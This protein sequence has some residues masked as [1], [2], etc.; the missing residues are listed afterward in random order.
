MKRLTYAVIVLLVALA[1]FANE[2]EG[3]IRVACVGNSV[4][5][6]FR[7]P[8]RERTAYPVVLQNLLGNHYE[9]RNF[10]HSGATLLKRGHK[11]YMS[12]SEFSAALD[13]AADIVV[14]HLGLNDTDPRN[15]PDFKEDFITDYRALIDSF[16]CANPKAKIW[17]CKMTPIFHWHPRF[18]SGTRD[19]HGQ[20]QKRI[21]QVARTADVSLIDFYESLHK[22]PDLFPDA[23]HP[24]ANGAAILARTVYGAITGDYGGLQLPEL[25][26]NGMVVQRNKEI[27]FH[28][29]ADA[30]ERVE[31]KFGKESHAVVAGG[32]GRWRVN[33][34]AR[35]AGGPYDLAFR[36]K[37]KKISFTD[38]WTGDVW[39]CSGQSNMEFRS[40][41]S[42]TAKQDE[43]D[44]D[45]HPHI[46][47]F[48]M[49][50]KFR[51]DAVEWGDSAL[52]LTNELQHLQMGPW[53][54]C[55]A[56][57]VKT[58]SAVAF[59]FGR[60]L[61]DSLHVPIG[62]ICNAVGGSTTESWIDRGTLERDYP[63]ILYDWL[64]ND[65]TQAWARSRAAQN[66][67]Q[68]ENKFQRHPYEPCYLYEA[69]ILP[70]E[71]YAI[72]GIIWYQGESNAHNVEL[73]ERLFGL[74]EKSW[75]ANWGEQL[76]F[77]F[78]QLSS[79]NRP[80]WPTF[81][82]SQRLLAERLP[83]TWMAVST[84]VGDSLDVHPRNK[85]VVGE[86]LAM[87]A[88][89]HTY[90]FCLTS[91]GPTLAD[92]RQRGSQLVLS[93]KHADGMSVTRGFEIAG[94]DGL[95]KDA[96]AIVEGTRIILSA[97]GVKKPVSVR[98]G[99]QPFTRADLRNKQGLPASTFM[100][101]DIH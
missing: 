35:E 52:K 73:H 25:Y 62:L 19:W 58:F 8:E 92:A 37:K 26:G 70:L 78:V 89:N 43:A 47:L 48:N 13:F 6:G 86:R 75:R 56:A 18:Q 84:D 29:I 67:K 46:R 15:W 90:G 53:Q 63:P 2:P 9:V 17:I 65:H 34:K 54:K 45:M 1:T 36:T 7:L 91:Q 80:S 41:Q 55:N 22:R 74:L 97:K 72:K 81:R 64:H 42:T 93:F 44:A 101:E 60:V 4:T 3:K 87:Q 66:I 61:S 10:G 98:Y 27:T 5:Y 100:I 59:N 24:D 16:R 21:E 11:P 28:G 49:P 82:N 31:V 23:L 14:I 12:Q 83:K 88:L 69:G 33:F 20:I 76:P 94:D 68:S 32:D 57:S 77:Y 38:V 51:T 40:S 50:A 85:R 95:Y 99:W 96:K 39:L 30:G 79:L 71:K